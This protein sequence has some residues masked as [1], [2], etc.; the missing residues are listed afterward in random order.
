MNKAV[1]YINLRVNPKQE[2]EILG[3][4]VGKD[5]SVS[6][7]DYLVAGTYG[8]PAARRRTAVQIALGPEIIS[9]LKEIAVVEGPC[10]LHRGVLTFQDGSTID[11]CQLIDQYEGA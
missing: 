8:P 9:A 5:G 1:G 2:H 7:Q 6:E 11:L 4:Y 3:R 10:S